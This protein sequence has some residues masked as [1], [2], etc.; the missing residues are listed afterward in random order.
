MRRR[1]EPQK[2]RHKSLCDGYTRRGGGIILRGG[3][4]NNAEESSLDRASRA[5]R[6]GTDLMALARKSFRHRL[7]NNSLAGGQKGAHLFGAVAGRDF[8]SSGWAPPKPKPL[9]LISL[10]NRRFFPLFPKMAEAPQRCEA[11]RRGDGA[12]S[13][14]RPQSLSS[15]SRIKHHYH[16]AGRRFVA[17]C[18]KATIFL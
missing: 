14:D 17:A 7:R 11:N 9:P 4:G 13:A 8:S 12:R 15:P 5:R 1:Q 2:M 10:L 3:G 16:A 6:G 18:A